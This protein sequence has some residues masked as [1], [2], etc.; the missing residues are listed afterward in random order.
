MLH[1]DRHSIVYDTC[2]LT[3]NINFRAV[4]Y[5]F[6]HRHWSKGH[7]SRTRYPWRRVRSWT[8]FILTRS[9]ISQRSNCTNS[10]RFDVQ[11]ATDRVSKL[12]SALFIDYYRLKPVV[13]TRHGHQAKG[14]HTETRGQ[15]CPLYPSWRSTAE[16]NRHQEGKKSGDKVRRVWIFFF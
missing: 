2:K 15:C 4:C 8:L 6:D 11:E 5:R 10:S 3:T 14:Q 12:F 9:L 7:S 13:K 16:T 1:T